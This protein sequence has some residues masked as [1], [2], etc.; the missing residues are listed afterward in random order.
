MVGIS[1]L[2]LLT[3]LGSMWDSVSTMLDHTRQA[4]Y[5]IS[6]LGLGAM[7]LQGCQWLAEALTRL[8]PLASTISGIL[9]TPAAGASASAII[10]ALPATVAL[11]GSTVT[12]IFAA[13]TSTFGCLWRT[14]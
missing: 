1:A 10:P 4:V 13:L 3:T 2:F 9:F 11:S 12:I 6:Y 5:G 8:S 14:P 7:L